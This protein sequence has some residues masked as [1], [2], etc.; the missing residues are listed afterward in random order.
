MALNA[1]AVLK[2]TRLD[3]YFG[4]VGL[5]KPAD[6]KNPGASWEHVGHSTMEDILSQNTEGGESTQLG[7]IQNN[8]LRTSVTAAVRSFTLNLM[9]WDAATLKL[10]YGKNTVV[11]DDGE[12]QI[13]RQPQPSEGSLLIVIREGDNVAG[14]FS[15][16]ASAIGDGDFSI[17]D[18]DS[19]ATIPVKFTPQGL[20]E[21][22]HAMSFIPIQK[23]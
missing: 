8:A 15:K 13:P 1:N 7:S 21:D 22:E 17:S 18:T 11:G 4:E 20:D 9:Q 5:E 14:F 10:Y 23:A 19:L 6:L 12:L 3:A 2:P 16:K